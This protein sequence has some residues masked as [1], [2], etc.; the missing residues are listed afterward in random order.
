MQPRTSAIS[1]DGVGSESLLVKAAV[2]G[3]AEI[4]NNHEGKQ[5][6]ATQVIKTS[7][8]GH[9]LKDSRSKEGVWVYRASVGVWF[10]DLQMLGSR[11]ECLWGRKGRATTARGQCTAPV[12]AVK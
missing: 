3:H 10:K 5:L 1:N 8:A 12:G 4:R 9:V 6:A 2:Y 7:E 11:G